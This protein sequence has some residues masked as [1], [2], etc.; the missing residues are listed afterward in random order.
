MS[1]S[2]VLPTDDIKQVPEDAATRQAVRS[3]AAQVAVGLD[4]SRSP[5]R[6]DLERFG[7]ILLE[8]LGLPGRYLGFAMVAVSNEFWQPI[9]EA[10]P[11]DRRLF[12][13]PHCLSDRKA[14]AGTYDSIGLNC[15]SCGNC[16][17]RDLKL[18]AE[19]L[20]YSVIVAE[21]TSSVLMKVLDGEADAIFGVACLDSLEKS[22]Q[23]IVEL[24]VPHV[25][26]PL[27]KDGCVD[28][29]VEIDRIHALLGA[30]TSPS[31]ASPRSYIP[32]LRETALMFQPPLF[33]DLLAPYVELAESA[34]GNEGKAATVEDIAL[35]WLKAGGK[36]LRPFVTIVSYLIARHGMIILDRGK[37]I[38][39]IIPLSIRR[40]ALAI[41][42]LHKA[43]LVHDDIED[44][45][46]FRYGR[47]TL[48]R[49][50]GIGQAINIGDF[51]IGLGYRLIAGEMTSLGS[52]CIGDILNLLSH[53]HLE[54]CRGQGAELQFQNRPWEPH[55]PMDVMKTYAQKTAPAFEAAIHAGL[56]AAGVNIQINTLRRFST[57]L[58]EGYQIRN[59]LD[60][61]QADDLNKRKRGL[62]VLANRP[63]ILRVFAM[64]N[65]CES[66]LMELAESDGKFPPDYRLEQVRRLYC[67][68][69]AFAKAEMLYQKLRDRAL[70]SAAEF[71]TDD[72]RELMRF[73]VRMV[74]RESAYSQAPA[75]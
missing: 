71:P 11:F 20:G 14:C 34:D 17:I 55:K 47:P 30:E 65:G 12:L 33:S 37:E 62:D 28:T 15:A 50:H 72:I 2:T 66:A 64:E 4:R 40:L 8:R 42:A 68:S 26:V 52:D 73:L 60:D 1:T 44:D 45:D 56:R 58:G 6:E 29:E 69:G 19:Q 46:E 21:G 63:T 53:A 54:L 74:L 23:R 43:S 57:Y 13:L 75:S 51:L 38:N 10:I 67:Q 31:R 7:K 61:W 27:L 35:D 9:F 16:E 39:E 18:E 24:G 36:R 41:E 70:N 32:L 22:F 48:H 5:L 59:D 3:V 49:T 25:A